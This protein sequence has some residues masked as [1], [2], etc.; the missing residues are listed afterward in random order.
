MEDHP[1]ED[2]SA[3]GL[4]VANAYLQSLQSWRCQ[5][6]P[7]TPAAFDEVLCGQMPRRTEGDSRQPGQE[8]R[9]HRRRKSAVSAAASRPG[10]DPDPHPQGTPNAS[11]LDPQTWHDGAPPIR[12]SDY[13]RPGCAN[14]GVARART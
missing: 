1:L 11:G 10:P 3:E 13:A 12:N 14:V 7:S 2:F 8:D 9:R 6:C 4:Q 5:D